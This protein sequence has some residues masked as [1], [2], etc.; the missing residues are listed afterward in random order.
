MK[1]PYR[2]F[3]RG[4]TLNGTVHVS[5]D[6]QYTVED[7]EIMVLRNEAY[8]HVHRR[9]YVRPRLFV[10]AFVSAD[11]E[12]VPPGNTVPFAYTI[13][14]DAPYT[15]DNGPTRITWYILASTVSRLT[16]EI[17]SY[18]GRLSHPLRISHA[19]K[20][21]PGTVFREF[22]VL[23]HVLKSTS[24][25][26]SVPLPACKKYSKLITKYRPFH[27]WRYSLFCKSKHLEVFMKKDSFSPGD[28]LSGI[29]HFIRDFNSVDIKI[30]L[31][32]LTK[33][34]YSDVTEE[35]QVI[36]HTRGSFNMGS[37]FPFSYHIPVRRYPT[38][39][40]EYSRI[41]WMVRAV[42]SNLF[43]F[44]K[45]AEREIVIKPLVF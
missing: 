5:S 1:I 12:I 38:Q 42:V 19:V 30:Y 34:K 11:M 24:P 28:E 43:R 14:E 35:E 13:P 36:A 6:S 40:T 3:L 17:V 23:P 41:W 18:I 15:F 39:K 21:I 22:V 20:L 25:P 37:S 27:L 32:F 9:S 44:T 2:P 45:V 10:D 26:R 16:P 31:V 4:E 7:L 29:L 33:S 8:P